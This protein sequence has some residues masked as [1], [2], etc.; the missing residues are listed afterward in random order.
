M[1]ILHLILYKQK[2]EKV[3][4][5]QKWFSYNFKFWNL[6]KTYTNGSVDENVKTGQP[7]PASPML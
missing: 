1:N 4:K 3:E 7:T 2:F 5:V 6:L